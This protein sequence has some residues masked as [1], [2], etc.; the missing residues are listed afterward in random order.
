M[1]CWPYPDVLLAS[2]TSSAE[3]LGAQE[4]INL[5]LAEL[6]ELLACT[7]EL[8]QKLERKGG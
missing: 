7:E 1:L 4:R 8:G 5:A 2:D 3:R 6:A